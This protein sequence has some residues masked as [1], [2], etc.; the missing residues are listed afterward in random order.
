MLERLGAA[1]TQEEPADEAIEASPTDDDQQDDEQPAEEVAETPEDDGFVELELE[2][3]TVRVPQEVKDGYLRQS[4][5]TRK[6]QDL[7]SLQRQA[8]A[9]VQQQQLVS[10]F[11]EQTK[12]D[13]QRLAQIKGELARYRQI[14][15]TNLDTDQYIKT[16]AYLD[17]L[18]DQASEIEKTLTEKATDVQQKYQRLRQES[19][20]NAYDYIARSIKEWQ[21]GSSVEREVAGYASTSG[22]PPEVFADLAVMYPGAAV[23]FYKAA[24]FDKLQATKGT[25]VKAATKAPPVVKPGAVTSNQ[26]SAAQRYKKDRELLKTTGSRD[27]GVRIFERLLSKG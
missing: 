13:Q 8:Q 18:K 25:A 10:Q 20:R 9:T 26:S 2:G 16:R 7:A 22:V 17:Q 3:K 12:D 1:I 11:N 21:P 24:Q 6:T 4:D 27:A 5:Y 14:D 15:L 23:A 19:A